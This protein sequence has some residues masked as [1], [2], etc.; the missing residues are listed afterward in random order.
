MTFITGC[1]ILKK[2]DNV[3]TDESK[4][5]V[6]YKQI[7]ALNLTNSDFNI[8]KAEIDIII[9]SEREKMLGYIKYKEP[10]TYL[11]SVR[12]RTGIE[13]ARILITSDT[14]MVNDRINK[15]LYYGS[16]DYLNRKYGITTGLLPVIIGDFIIDNDD[17]EIIACAKNEAYINTEI[18]GKKIHFKIDCEKTKVTGVNIEDVITEKMLKIEFSKF[19]RD[20]YCSIARSI[21]IESNEEDE[22][23]EINIDRLEF[24][25]E[26]DITFIPGKKYEKILLK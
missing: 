5:G 18:V 9:G 23:I 10:E 3:R 2:V 24:V 16:T 4:N 20:A 17:N 22:R 19:K 1:A 7:R 11:I 21:T 6:S 8:I 13:G 26:N 14:I 15:K 25:L 12:N